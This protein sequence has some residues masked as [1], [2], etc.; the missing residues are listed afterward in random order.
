MKTKTRKGTLSD[1]IEA[2]STIDIVEAF[3]VPHKTRRD[4][5]YLL[6][7]GHPDKHFGSCYIDKNDDGYYC[8]VCGAQVRKWNMVL[9]L[10]G[11]NKS[12]AYEWFFQ[13]SGLSPSTI[14]YN[15][16]MRVVT[17][18]IK[19][20]EQYVNNQVVYNDIYSCEKIDTSYGRTAKGSYLYSERSI[21]NPLL[22]LYKSNK[23]IF[24]HIVSKKLEHYIERISVKLHAYEKDKK[25]CLHIE[26]VDLIANEE[27]A[28]IC[29]KKIDKAR[30]LM[31]E[32][33][34][35]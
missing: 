1:A 11:N 2:V 19:E 35:L 5:T 16:P 12:A 7:P 20:L 17:K 9:Q 28:N 3:D 31:M 24:K 29:R 33:Q 34:K 8:Y 15:D 32:V 25:E 4:K 27:L 14:N 6:C 30:D 10:N 22:E 26:N 23:T 21:S 18:L 13:T